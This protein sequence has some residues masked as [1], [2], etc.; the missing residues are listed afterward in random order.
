M[1]TIIGAVIL[2]LSFQALADTKSEKIG[3]LM[4]ALGLVET[5]KQQIEQGKEYNRK[6][7]TQ[8]MDQV[9]SQLNPNEDFK[10]RFK[11]AADGFIKKTEAPWT[12]EKIVSVWA[13]YYAPDF[14]EEELDQLIAFYSSPLGQKD[15]QVTRKAMKGFSKYFEEASQPIT[16][17][18]TNEYIE[19]LK[20][21]AT[22]CNC[23]K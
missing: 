16:Q 10:Q 7:S 9:L 19:Q 15:I 2:T 23:A 11:T 13:S 5:W 8:I 20:I 21:I 3:R 4:D 1:R 6:V 22:Q 12:A 18:A 14:S 17:S